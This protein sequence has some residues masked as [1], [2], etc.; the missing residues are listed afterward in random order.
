MDDFRLHC[1][2]RMAGNDVAHSNVITETDQFGLRLDALP[3]W[4][5]SRVG[6]VRLEVPALEAMWGKY[7]A[8]PFSTGNHVVQLLSQ[9]WLLVFHF[10]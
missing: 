9:F 8:S 4:V 6:L 1:R 3:L 7:R 10:G 5:I 2:R